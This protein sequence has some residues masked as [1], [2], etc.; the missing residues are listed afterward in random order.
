MIGLDEPH[1]ISFLANV[2]SLWFAVSDNE[3][4]SSEPVSPIDFVHSLIDVQAR[5]TTALLSVLR[6]F[7]D[8]PLLALRIDRELVRRTHRL[9]TWLETLDDVVI[10]RVARQTEPFQDGDQYW[11]EL[12]W[13]DGTALSVGVLVDSNWA[14]AL[15]DALL[16]PDEITAIESLVTVGIDDADLMTFEPITA[17]DARAQISEAIDRGDMMFPP[18]STESWPQARPI[19]EWVLRMLP[20]GGVGFPEYDLDGPARE[21]LAARFL[22]SDEAKGLGPFVAETVDTLV[23]F[24]GFSCGDPLRWSPIKIRYL[25]LD[26]WHRKVIQS[27]D[28]DRELPRILRAFVR[29]CGRL[30]GLPPAFIDRNL[31]TIDD[32]EPDFLAEIKTPRR[33]TAVELAR[34][35]VGLPIDYEYQNEDEDEDL[36]GVLMRELANRVGGWDALDALDAAP[37]PDEPLA[38]EDVA[39]DILPAVLAASDALDEEI[40]QRG[41]SNP[42]ELRTAGRR[43][44]AR[45]ALADPGAWR[46]KANPASTA[47]AIAYVLY[48][49]NGLLRS[50]LPVKDLVASFGLKSAPHSRIKV[51]RRAGFG[52]AWDGDV[53]L[54]TSASRQEIMELRVRWQGL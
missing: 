27:E 42:V 11:F 1:P 43:L 21:A 31:A 16:V 46:R 33:D 8:D 47:C 20:E 52:D 29:W 9:P 6:L 39:D 45:L 17:A 22:A 34:L 48:D 13:P 30:V 2:S 23:W 41:L 32:S 53:S 3:F 14:F 54:M 25:L 49:V 35:A 5:Q 18:H 37:L 36:K 26:W 38:L 4:T 44:V 12:G 19:V 51:F 10:K 7:V 50:T 24:A 40:S 28:A 15:K